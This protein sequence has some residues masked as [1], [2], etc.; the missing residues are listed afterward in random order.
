MAQ[1][2]QIING[3]HTE[4]LVQVYADR[5]LALLTQLGKVGYLVR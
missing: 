5:T 4:L 2:A 1:I 3:T